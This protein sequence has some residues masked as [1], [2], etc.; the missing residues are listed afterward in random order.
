MK[1]PPPDPILLI[2]DALITELDRRFPMSNPRVTDTERQIF[3]RAGQRDIIEF[4]KREHERA[5]GVANTAKELLDS[6]VRK[7]N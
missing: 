2:P 7:Q 3:F 1:T 6:D 4:L 5:R